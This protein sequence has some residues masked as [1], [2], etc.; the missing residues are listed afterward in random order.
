VDT[1]F[2]ALL[3][4]EM[5]PLALPAPAGTKLTVKALDWPGPSVMG[6]AS[7]FMANPLPVIVA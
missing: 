5:L 2:A 7:P 6:S 4:T 3:T 1:E